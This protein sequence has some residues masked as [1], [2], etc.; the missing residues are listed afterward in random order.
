M[1]WG[2]L[3]WVFLYM[4]VLGAT[5][6]H[7][8]GICTLPATGGADFVLAF[9][10]VCPASVSFTTFRWFLGDFSK[11]DFEFGWLEN[12]YVY[13]DDDDDVDRKSHTSINLMCENEFSR[14]YSDRLCYRFVICNS[15]C[16]LFM[17][18][19]PRSLLPFARDG[20]FHAVVAWQLTSLLW[21]WCCW[22]RG[23]FPKFRASRC[24]RNCHWRF[25]EMEFWTY[26][27][28][29]FLEYVFICQR[30]L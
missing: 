4:A 12:T 8:L 28:I 26:V 21:A 23:C 10:I 6:S 22:R 20:M 17:D 9:R 13:H 11:D 25:R 15:S 1:F 14:K 29:C 16:G 2:F 19:N 3:R 24:L 5:R 18:V 27:Q 30:R 7:G